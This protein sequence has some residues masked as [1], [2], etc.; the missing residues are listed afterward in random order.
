M[1]ANFLSLTGTLPSPTGTFRSQTVKSV[2][3]ERNIEVS[4]SNIA[5]GD[6]NIPAANRKILQF[7]RY[8][9]IPNMQ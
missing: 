2:C 7:D 3:F 5:V 9:R 8:G 1:T 6:R 4:D